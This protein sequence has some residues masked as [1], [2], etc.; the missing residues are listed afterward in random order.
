M[1]TRKIEL[2]IVYQGVNITEQIKDYIE[3]LSYIDIAS[4]SSDSITLQLNNLSKKW[5]NEW[6]PQKED[7]IIME[8]KIKNREKEGTNEIIPCGKFML[9]DLS[10]SGSPLICN[11]GATSVPQNEGFKAQ[12]RTC[13]WEKLTIYQIAKKIATN[14]KI[15]LFYE[16]EE[17][18]VDTIEQSEETDSKFLY[19][20]CKS[21][22]LAMKVFAKKICIFEEEIYEAKEPV[23]TLKA[24][25]IIKWSYNT[26]IAGSY[27]G[28]RLSYSDP[29]NDHEIMVEFG[30]KTRLLELNEKADNY[31]DAEKK[32]K[33]RLHEENKKMTTMEI[34]IPANPKI[35]ASSVISIKQLGKLD[36]NYYVEQIRHKIDGKSAYTMSLSVRKV[37]TKGEKTEKMIEETEN[38][39]Y[40]VKTGDTL[41]DIA[42]KYLNSGIKCKEIYETNKDIIE[43]VAKE[44]GKQNSKQGHWIW[45]GTELIIPK[46]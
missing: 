29:K 6:M 28:V 2:N 33:A 14:A 34:T 43:K 32:A 22:G 10:F 7:E 12:K 38:I 42:K 5:I 35:F 17:I 3:S 19:E 21:Y 41:W 46:E 11:I 45:A 24:E 26:T 40:I 23:E 18:L 27:T 44:H 30:D 39:S 16:A 36:G 1:E 31:A 13:T 25:S 9:D 15:E 20:L 8:I 4:G 37:V